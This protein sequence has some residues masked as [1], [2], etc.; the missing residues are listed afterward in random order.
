MRQQTGFTLIELI[1][2]TLILALLASFAI[3]SFLHA[4]R[5][6]HRAEAIAL[7]MDLQ[8]R[9]SQWRSAHSRYAD[10]LTQLRASSQHP[11]LRHYQLSLSEVASNTYRLRAIALA[12]GGM[13]EDRIDGV[14][15]STLQI[16]QS[17]Q[18]SPPICW[19]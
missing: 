18:R 11:A 17:G 14:D 13:R 5:K 9:Q 1:A 6:S 10:S 4:I 7:L 12:S 16:D 2:A 3:P 8:L 19:Q 15:C